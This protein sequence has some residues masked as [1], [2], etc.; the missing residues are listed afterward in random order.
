MMES[1]TI[2]TEG[3]IRGEGG[4]KVRHRHRSK[5]QAGVVVGSRQRVGDHLGV[6]RGESTAGCAWRKEGVRGPP[7]GS[8]G[9]ESGTTAEGG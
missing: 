7:A 6:M 8:G 5:V 1:P 9:G 4:G 2:R 3:M